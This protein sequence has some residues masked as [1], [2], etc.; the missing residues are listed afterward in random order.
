MSADTA[1]F[2]GFEPRRIEGAGATIACVV[3]GAGPPVLLLHGFPQT[4][5]MWHRV[6]PALARSRTVVAA[7]LRGYGDS[8][9]P[10]SDATHAAFSKRAM[11]ADMVA[12]MRSLGHPRFD[13]VGH[14]RGGRVAHRLAADH[15]QAV[16]RVAV[17][18]IAPTLAMYEKTDRAF[19]TAYYHWFFLIQPEP[20]P[21]RM[22]GADPGAYLRTKIGGWGS[23]G[24]SFFDP[25]AL[26][27][28]LRCYRDPATIHASCEDYRASA[29][30]DLEHDAADRAAG[31]RLRGPLL[32]L[33][34]ERGVVHRL[35]DPLAEWRAVADDVS[36][37]SL[38]CGHYVAEEAPEQTLAELQSFLAQDR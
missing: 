38:P 20:L 30:I 2:P 25:R 35:F 23:A 4:R 36:G 19:A 12:V 21:E 16:R 37:R 27:E 9:K 29:S 33:W 32:V 13:L 11:A 18:D 3:G 6:A 34:G 17:L 31:A 14:D 28:Y 15:P 8:S 24:M 1:L 7:D 26:D 22:I 10:P 5:A